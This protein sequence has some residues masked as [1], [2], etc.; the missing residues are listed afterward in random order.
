[1]SDA[2]A[3]FPFDI[4]DS[5]RVREDVEDSDYPGEEIGGWQGRVV[6]IADE[7][8]SLLEV[9]WD[10]VTLKEMPKST[11]REAAL[12]GLDW[13]RYHVDGADLQAADPRD[14]PQ[15]V[16]RVQNELREELKWV[17]LDEPEEELIR[18]VES[19]IDSDDEQAL[20][21]IWKT[22]LTDRLSFPFD[23][24]VAEPQDGDPFQYGDQ[25]T[26]KNILLLDSLYGLLA[27]LQHGR[28]TKHLPLV[29]LE[30]ADENSENRIL[31]RAYRNWFFNR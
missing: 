23:A 12:D 13:T 14:A 7:E 10:S 29:D 15:D 21:T 4:G 30:A 19:Q 26:V 25:V 9:E 18:H 11:L 31:L 27:V 8:S 1:M 22:E 3:N 28:S 16:R 5:V 24:R 20:L 17:Y 2:L 6:D